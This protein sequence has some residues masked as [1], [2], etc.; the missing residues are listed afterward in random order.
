LDARATAITEPMKLAAA[1]A[2]AGVV[3]P[4]ELHPSYII[5]SVF[6]PDVAPAVAEAVR[7]TVK[8]EG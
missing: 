3:G 8:A 7:Q 6:N 1:R 2:I 4:D 5:P